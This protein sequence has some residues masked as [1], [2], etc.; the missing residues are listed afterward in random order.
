M[1]PTLDQHV[2][3][4]RTIAQDLDRG[5]P[6]L[7]ALEHAGARL[8]GTDFHA[9]ASA[10][11]GEIGAGA[12][13]SEAMSKHPSAFSR[14]V[15]LMVR[16][17]EAGGVLDVIARRIAEGLQDGSFPLPGSP[18]EDDPVR[19]CRAF[20]TLL[21]S[22]VPI[23]ETLDRLREEVCGPKLD[24]AARTIADGI[25]DGKSMADAMRER[26]DLFPDE[27]CV[28]VAIGEQQGSLDEQ[29]FRIAD[30]LETADLASLVP[31]AGT[32]QALD[33]SGQ[34]PPIVKIVGLILTQAVR[35]KAS[36]V[37]FEPVEDGLKIRYRIDGALYEMQPPPPHLTSHI[38]NR[39]KIMGDMDIAERRL[40]QDARIHFDI[41]G[42]PYDLR[43]STVPTVHG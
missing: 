8:Q 21:W 14:C 13:L 29:A 30:A 32:P 39:L 38:I 34:A 19:A 24:E 15:T 37:H 41:D 4:W 23:L 18:K 26:P 42:K 5:R 31:G 33:P 2:T 43:V 3:F 12:G 11:M 27:V 1:P 17:G 36:D 20:G 7:P 6:L 40:P 22:G 28:A 16:V 9:A 10:L 25:R 35:D